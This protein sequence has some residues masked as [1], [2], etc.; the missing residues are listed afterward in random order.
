MMTQ[1]MIFIHAGIVLIFGIYLACAF[2]G[3]RF[4]KKSCLLLLALC[5][6]CGVLQSALT[7]T[8]STLAVKQL[9]P[10]I[11]HV[12]LFLVLT[13]IYKKTIAASFVSICTAY[14]CCQPSKWLGILILHYTHN[15]SAEY[16]ARCI[17]LLIIFPIIYILFS[18]YMSVI[19][20]RDTRSVFVFGITPIIYYLFDYATTVYTNFWSD[21]A[22]I[23]AELISSFLCFIFLIFCIVYHREYEQKADAHRR[24]QI[25]RITANAQKK[26][27]E[28]IQNSVHEMRIIRHDMRHFLANLSVCLNNE[29]IPTARQMIASYIDGIDATVLKTYCSQPTL[30]YLIT[31]FDHRCQKAQIKFNCT[32]AIDRLNCDETM[33][34][35]II[36]NALDNAINAQAALPEYQ[37]HI[38]FMLKTHNNKLLLSI[39]NP[40]LE[41]PKFVNDIPVSSKAGHGYG[42]QSILLLTERMGGSCQ[43]LT[44]HNQFILRIIL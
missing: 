21:Y 1:I 33:L 7:I 37:R 32:V 26:E 18:G 36:S 23:Y 31:N 8:A 29:D 13:C 14:L 41:K 40:F 2:A 11:T 35:S 34:A 15:P 16:I 38:D 28:A 39:Q 6:V 44:L 10:L 20:N 22:Q 25:I 17:A 19:F 27:A 24:E 3:V 9:Y 30:N 42:T 12:P 43:F 4:N 5:L